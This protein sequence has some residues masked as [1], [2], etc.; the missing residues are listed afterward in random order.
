LLAI[1]SSNG[2]IPDALNPFK[3]YFF[4]HV[5]FYCSC[6]LN[7]AAIV[8]VSCDGHSLSYNI[9]VHLRPV[10]FYKNGDELIYILLHEDN[11]NLTSGLTFDSFIKIISITEDQKSIRTSPLVNNLPGHFLLAKLHI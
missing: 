8:A 5:A 1:G 6:R 3:F 10:Y 11:V 2:D 9:Y 4:A 7:H